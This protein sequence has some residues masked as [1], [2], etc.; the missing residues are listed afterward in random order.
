MNPEVQQI[1]LDA[2]NKGIYKKNIHYMFSPNADPAEFA[3]VKKMGASP[4]MSAWM[5]QQSHRK[6]GVQMQVAKAVSNDLMSSDFS[7]AAKIENVPWAAPVIEVYFEDPLLP[8]ILLMKTD[9][10]QLQVWFPEIDCGK[11]QGEYI[12]GLM[13]E[14]SGEFTGKLLS[15]Q[16]KPDMYDVFLATGHTTKMDTGL[17]SSELTEQDNCSMAFMVHLA[18]K[19]FVF[20]SMPAYKP[21]SIVRKQMTFGGKPDVKG[22]PNRPSFHVVYAPKVIYPKHESNLSASGKAFLGRRG[23]MHW[24]LHERFV[25]RKGSWDFMAPIPNPKTGKYPEVNIIKV[26]KPS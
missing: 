17:F 25:N 11:L 16:L 15:L 19:V 13:Q 20:A 18:L 26:R 14:G 1:A 5:I 8:T 24:Y 2:F 12:T 7:T 4:A 6:A 9:P 22:R 10:T 3:Y 21:K 23:H